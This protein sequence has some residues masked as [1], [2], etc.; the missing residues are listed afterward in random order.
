MN[1]FN[2]GSY[3]KGIIA[4]IY[5]LLFYL[6]FKRV[7]LLE[8]RFKTKVGEIDLIFCKGELL[9]FVEVK[10]RS[11]S[12]IFDVIDNKSLNRIT[13]AAQ[14]FLKRKGR[15]FQSYNSRIDVCYVNKF[16]KLTQKINVSG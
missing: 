16:F 12:D 14:S 5:V 11:N 6:I 2:M 7:R 13:N 1:S 9:I 15:K 3:Q 4:E 10:Y 8:R